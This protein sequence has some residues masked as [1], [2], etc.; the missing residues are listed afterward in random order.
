MSFIQRLQVPQK[1]LPERLLE[2]TFELPCSIRDKIGFISQCCDVNPKLSANAIKLY[3]AVTD[4]A[5]FLRYFWQWML[6]IYKT[7]L[8][9]WQCDHMLESQ[10]NLNAS[11][12]VATVVLHQL[13]CYK[14]SQ[15]SP[16]ALS[17][18]CKQIWCQQLSK[19]AQ[20][21]HSASRPLIVYIWSFQ[22]NILT[23]I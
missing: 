15:K 11:Q 12:I 9:H 2:R 19:I 20:Y 16:L 1:C 8:R 18:F 3:S 21:G 23:T 10:S 4:V 14:T 5:V 6:C 13:I 22:T 7:S 17:Y